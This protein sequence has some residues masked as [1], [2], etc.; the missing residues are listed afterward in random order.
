MVDGVQTYLIYSY[1][2]P[3]ACLKKSTQIL[4]HN[5]CIVIAVLSDPT[6]TCCISFIANLIRS[7]FAWN[8][9]GIVLSTIN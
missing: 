2:A 9:V 1:K 3:A 6:A 7:S 4:P 5:H 8:I